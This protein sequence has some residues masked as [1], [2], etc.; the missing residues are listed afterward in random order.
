MLKTVAAALIAFAGL[1][2]AT[3]YAQNFRLDWKGNRQVDFGVEKITAPNFEGKNFQ[4]DG[5]RLYY[6]VRQPAA[7]QQLE[8][9]NL[10]W[11][12]IPETA[13]EMI[14]KEQLPQQDLAEVNYITLEGQR[15]ADITVAALKYVEGKIYRLTGFSLR[16]SSQPAARGYVQLGSTENPLKNGTFY[17]IK[18]DKSG[19][20]K[21]TADFLRANGINPATVNPRNL[22]VYGNGGLMLPE[23][24]QDW[25][26]AALQEDAIQ[27]VG[28][29]DGVWNDG[30][31][32]L[33]YAQ[34]PHGFNL[35][36]NNTGGN[37]RR[38]TRFLDRPAHSKNIYEEA[39]YYY[40]S[41]D[42]GA[43]KRVTAADES[44]PQ[45]LIS[46]YDDYQFID[47]DERN[48]M[49]VGRTWVE[50][51]SFS[52]AK[53]VTLNTRLPL[54]SRDE[55]TFRFRVIGLNAAGTQFSA[56]L[57]NTNPYSLSPATNAAPY[58][59][60]A[61]GKTATGFSGNTLTF[62]FNASTTANPSAQYY[63]DYVEAQYK[64]DLSFNGSQMNFRDFSLPTGS[65]ELFGFSLSNA[66]GVE[67]IWDV[68]DVTN[69]QRKVNKSG[70]SS[71]FNFGYNTTNATFNNEFVAFRADAAF[72]PAF[73]G[74]IDNQDLASI[75]NIDYLILA[76]T[77]YL[78]EA[79]R[80]ADYHKTRN[81]YTT[82]VV[83]LSKI[84][85]EFSSGSQDITAIRDFI[86]KLNQ[87]A[88]TLENV[89]LLGDGSY[90]YKN[91]L[92]GNTNI[93]PVY[94]SEDSSG[95]IASFA[96][97]DYIVMTSPQS[98]GY[99]ANIIPDVPVGRLI[100]SNAAEMKLLVDKT[101]AYN[102]AL[103]GQSTP[104]GI[105]KTRFDFS[106]DDACD[107]GV[108]FHNVIEN[109]VKS[110][111][112]T[113]STDKP[114]YNVRKLY[115]D[116]YPQVNTAGGLAAPEIN[117]TIVSDFSNSLFQFYF[118]HGGINGWAQKRIFTVNDI[119]RINDYNNIYTR[120]PFVST[121][122]CEFTYWDEP[123]V[124]SAGEQLMKLRTGGTSAMITSSR[125]ID[126]QYGLDFTQNFLA[127]LTAVTNDAF[128]QLGAAHLSAKRAFG[129][130]ANHM[131]VNFLGDPAQRLTRPR[132][133]IQID[134]IQT[135]VAGQIR[136]L[137]FVKITGR[138]TNPDGS[139]NTN[140]SG[141]AQIYI[142]D[143]KLDKTTK[144]WN[145]LACMPPMAYKEEGTPIVKAVGTVTNGIFTAEFYVPNDI[146]YTLGTGRILA[147]AENGKEDVFNNFPVVIGGINPQGVQDNQ[148]PK[149][150][151]FMNNI[152][153][154]NG[155]IT[156]QNPT[157]LACVTD[158][159]GIN[160]TG[161]GVGH[162][163]V[164][165]LDGKVIETTVLNDYYNPGEGNG[166][167]FPT[168]AQYQK[169]N[170][171]YPFRNLAPG[172]HTLTFKIWDINNNST[173]ETLT[174]IVKDEA[175]QQ[176][177]LTKLLNWPNPFTDRTY[178]HFEHNCDDILD[179]N[180]QI[181][182]MTGRLVKT[183]SQPV[184]S[185]PFLQGYR[186][187]RQAI[188]WDGKDDFGDTVGK[189]TYIYRVFARSQNQERC[190]GGATAT[191]KMVVLK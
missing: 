182:T 183:I 166:C 48:L 65:G 138:V 51:A 129:G 16:P 71:V 11:E 80:M 81:G 111:F 67:Q 101:L 56:N 25:R 57:N 75:Q 97:D 8:A 100:G 107:T 96:T 9:F 14:S 174:F 93:F 131:R 87:P 108:P 70:N 164:T 15:Y 69:P 49:K 55:V 104:F 159:T 113:P 151:L 46:R 161:A 33:F 173:T 62:N 153:F 64:Q 37:V 54:N 61:Y 132:K 145:N 160:S 156:N 103:P 2:P 74:R 149:V 147:Y 26:Y 84:Y 142:Y 17:K 181:Y 189:G 59:P 68:S 39:S 42:K 12:A 119:N 47:N 154:A 91:R 92:A 178:I 112:E 168:L 82:Q 53:A 27:V 83:D 115:V 22:R 35:Y 143:K 177:Q 162:D 102:N 79:Q 85:N 179:V 106:V 105:W 171:T 135:P 5:S 78:G 136:A 187:P 120:L 41:F 6:N 31:Y 7:E 21:I 188:M 121:I 186:T 63:F 167:V 52:G 90:D 38:E 122:T 28:E 146:D 109:A 77:Q 184:I 172:E 1:L 72:T 24:N 110:I 19:I 43:G 126:V 134:N 140:F 148:P 152:N 44:L 128:P 94:Q 117:N 73:I 40:I 180:A 150:K 23:F 18:V 76:P 89:L 144:N 130:N 123:A 32:A 86:T 133:L 176:L 125:A 95:V 127:S 175:N 141:Q 116:A 139:L 163:I 10:Q 118:G 170:V 191:E 36:N 124:S 4:F 185:E 34:G 99:V 50:N 20:F 158:D 157:L 29:E 98:S 30:D 114:E 169:G 3:L 88:G 165:Y 60:M 13:L 58:L 190:P 66:G 137:D 155:G 45:E